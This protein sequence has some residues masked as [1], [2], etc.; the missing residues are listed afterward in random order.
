MKI[1][2]DNS[3][4]A[5]WT[6]ADAAPRVGLLGRWG[7]AGRGAMEK[8]QRKWAPLPAGPGFYP[9]IRN[10]SRWEI[11]ITSL[12]A[13][14]TATGNTPPAGASASPLPA[15]FSRIDTIIDRI[16]KNETGPTGTP[17]P[18][19]ARWALGLGGLALGAAAVAINVSYAPLSLLGLF[20]VSALTAAGAVSTLLLGGSAALLLSLAVKLKGKAPGNRREFDRLI[21]AMT[22]T[23]AELTHIARRLRKFGEPAASRLCQEISTR[24]TQ[25]EAVSA[26]G[27]LKEQFEKA[28]GSVLKP[29]AAKPADQIKVKFWEA[30][31]K[32]KPF[33]RALFHA[34][35]IGTAALAYHSGL[36][37]AGFILTFSC[38]C[39][40]VS[41]FLA[42]RRAARELKEVKDKRANDAKINASIGFIEEQADAADGMRVFQLDIIGENMKQGCVRVSYTFARDAAPV[43]GKVDI[44]NIAKD[45]ISQGVDEGKI[46]VRL[47]AALPIDTEVTVTFASSLLGK[48]VVKA[49]KVFQPGPLP[50]SP[51]TASQLDLKRIGWRTFSNLTDAALDGKKELPTGKAEL[52]NLSATLDS[53]KNQ[54]G[55]LALKGELPG[56]QKTA[57]ANI[58]ELLMQ[59]TQRIGETK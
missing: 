10:T 34:G 55:S 51:L 2:L 43:D 13:N 30:E 46:F 27:G 4:I 6:K 38:G 58:D 3:R 23:P 49:K 12:M 16:Q 42:N 1:F 14:K 31:K 18:S 53:A 52:E 37:V 36:H 29:E 20:G 57:R 28:E 45:K 19:K 48:E 39:V 24:L 56:D 9:G 32:I 41:H 47:P 44:V 8:L 35:E 17:G 21:D 59:I 22:G 15:K 54:L 33:N 26:A 50:N 40:I 25:M 7:A 5:P 11:P